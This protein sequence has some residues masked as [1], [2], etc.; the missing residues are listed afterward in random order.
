MGYCKYCQ[1]PKNNIVRKKETH[2]TNGIPVTSYWI[3]C[4]DCWE[5]LQKVS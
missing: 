5:K 4:K 3:G 2:V 1:R